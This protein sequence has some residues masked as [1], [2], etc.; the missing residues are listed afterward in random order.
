MKTY[1][2]TR[3]AFQDLSEIWNYTFD[4]WSEEQANKYYSILIA[5][6]INIASDKAYSSKPYF[7]ISNNLWGYRVQHH[8]IFYQIENN[9]VLVIRILHSSMD[10][11]SHFY[12][13][14]FI[15]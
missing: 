6:I 11:K 5:G 9:D 12:P 7:Q 13:S 15:V 14:V 2:L 4:N 10:L 1:H 3:K 8:I